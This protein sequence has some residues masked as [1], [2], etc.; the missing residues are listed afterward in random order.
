MPCNGGWVPSPAQHSSA[1][2]HLG[3]GPPTTS[4]PNRRCNMLML[5]KTKARIV[6]IAASSSRARPP[7]TW[8]LARSS[9]ARLTHT[10]TASRFRLNR[11]SECCDLLPA[12]LMCRR[13]R[14][15][16]VPQNSMHGGTL[17][18]SLSGHSLSLRGNFFRLDR[19]RFSWWN[20]RQDAVARIAVGS[21]DSGSP[22]PSLK[23]SSLPLFLLIYFSI[24]FLSNTG[25]F[26]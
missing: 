19:C 11:E 2:R 20:R 7:K 21:K 22:C 15:Y 9:R 8:A 13:H 17:S 16:R 23:A 24:C 3:L 25:V 5:E 10:A 26:T 14:S 1:L 12:I 18:S 6:M 4:S